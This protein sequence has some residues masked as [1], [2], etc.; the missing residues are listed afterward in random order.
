[1][2]TFQ[3]RLKEAINEGTDTVTIARFD[4][5]YRIRI[6][7]EVETFG[8]LRQ[9]NNLS[10]ERATP[11][12]LVGVIEGISQGLSDAVETIESAQK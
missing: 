9:H 10:V 12:R 7:R 8:I 3:E 4:S 6:E 5:Y 11:G 2:G 1:M